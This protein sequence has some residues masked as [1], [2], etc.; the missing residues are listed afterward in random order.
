MT[1]CSAPLPQT[2]PTESV[3][4][5][6]KSLRL[7]HMHHQWQELERQ[8]LQQQWTYAQFLL[9]IFSDSTMTVAAVD[10]LVHH[11]IIFEIQVESFRQQT[12]K[13]RALADDKNR[14]K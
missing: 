2:P 3:N 10:R 8:A 7:P 5:L 12:A 4:L 11:A 6:L 9:A 1:N 13:Q 14:P